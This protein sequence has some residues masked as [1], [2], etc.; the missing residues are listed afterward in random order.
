MTRNK[1]SVCMPVYNGSEYIGEA[2]KS[3]LNQTFED[4]SLIICDNCS[5]DPTE[6]I[7]RQFKDKRIKF[8]KNDSNLGLVGN[9]NSCLKMAEGEY[10][11]IF[12]HDDIMLPENLER[13]VRVLEDQSN[14]G[15]VHSNL[16][17]I[18]SIGKI[19]SNKMWCENSCRDYIE[20]GE[21]AFAQY[22]NYLPYGASIFIGAV[23]ARKACYER[24]GGFN[25][26]FIHCNDSEMW[27][28]MMLFYDVAC[29]GTPLVKYRVH[30]TSTSSGFGNYKSSEFLWE[31][32]EVACSVLSFYQNQILDAPRLEKCIKKSFS[33][34]ALNLSSQSVAEGKKKDGLA[35]LKDALKMDRSSAWRAYFWKRVLALAIGMRMVN[36]YQNTIGKCWI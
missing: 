21:K 29:I 8:F 3:V 26:A 20:S 7:V 16:Y 27:L 14:I 4:F 18:D 25:P 31:H 22:I 32:F 6:E 2:I 1:V 11:A 13:K 5:T 28:R 24:V 9:A 15:F 35:F 33:D 23:V 10:V 34:R 17:L 12:H 19:I 30:S 36:I